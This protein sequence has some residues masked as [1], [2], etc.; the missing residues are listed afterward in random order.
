LLGE[1]A[2]GGTYE[3]LRDQS[4]T[5]RIFGI[6]CRCLDLDALIRVK[7]AAGRPKDLEAIAEL[8]RILELRK[9]AE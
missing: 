5:V 3:N 8:E 9:Q 1:L 7:R 6:D 2:G 4:S